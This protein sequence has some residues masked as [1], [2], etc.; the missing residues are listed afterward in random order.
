[1]QTKA[2]S[3]TN[4]EISNHLDKDYPYWLQIFKEWDKSKEKVYIKSLNTDVVGSM[5]EVAFLNS[6]KIQIK[7]LHELHWTDRNAFEKVLES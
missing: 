7:L 3:F 2:F 4:N 1:M 6:Y 5:S